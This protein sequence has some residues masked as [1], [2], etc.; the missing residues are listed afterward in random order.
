M[1]TRNL[2]DNKKGGQHCD[3]NPRNGSSLQSNG[4]KS[5]NTSRQKEKTLCNIK[6]EKG[7]S[8]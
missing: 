4:I 8:S 1:K 6:N 7:G 3:P 5:K 2:K